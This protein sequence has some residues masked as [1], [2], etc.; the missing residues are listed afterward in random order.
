MK[1]Y[2]LTGDGEIGDGA[3]ARWAEAPPL[4]AEERW[5][6]RGEC[7][8]QSVLSRFPELFFSSQ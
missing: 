5:E 2:E 6:D 7:V 3:A 4:R 8:C 1:E